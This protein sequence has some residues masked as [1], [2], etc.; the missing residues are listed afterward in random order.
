MERTPASLTQSLL[1]SL[2]HHVALPALLPS[3]REANLA[4]INFELT[5]LLFNACTDLRNFATDDIFRTQWDCMR[6]AIKTA[7]L[8]NAG[9][10]L[11]SDSL[12]A[13]FRELGGKKVLIIHISGQ[14]AGLL[15]RRMQV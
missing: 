6:E 1:E 7:R 12:L 9:G 4:N 2:C 10:N 3:R 15:I 5:S 11:D 13:A 14:N 8:L